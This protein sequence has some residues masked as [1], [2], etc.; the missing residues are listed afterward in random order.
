MGSVRVQHEKREAQEGQGPEKV[1]Q[2]CLAERKRIRT[3][4]NTASPRRTKIPTPTH[5]P[6][7]IDTNTHRVGATETRTRIMYKRST[8]VYFFA[9]VTLPAKGQTILIN[10]HK[11]NKKK[12]W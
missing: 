10:E 4:K 3:A 2:C 11:F 9:T 7:R 1:E 12:I 5:T 6:P 8:L